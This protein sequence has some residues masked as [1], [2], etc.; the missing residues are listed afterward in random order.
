MGL[1]DAQK[2]RMLI[3]TW[4]ESAHEV[5]DGNEGSVRI[6]GHSCY[7]LAKNLF[8]FCLCLEI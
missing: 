5:S 4:T 8:T 6:R 2:T 7:I 1:V 3:G